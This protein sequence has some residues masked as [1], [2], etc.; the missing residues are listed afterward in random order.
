M[1]DQSLR[2]YYDQLLVTPIIRY[3]PCSPLTLTLI[4]GV[5][6]LLFIPALLWTSPAIALILLFASGYLDTLDGA[7]AR[8]RQQ[9]TAVG[10]V[11][12]IMTDRVVEFS[13]LF[14]LYLLDPVQRG[15]ATVLMLGSVFL[16]ITSFL[17]VGIFT[18]N[19]SGKSFHYS[20]GLME[21][22]EA[23][24]FFAAMTLLPG[25]FNLIAALFA[26]LVLI[27]A[28]IRIYEFIIQQGSHS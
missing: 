23:L 25:Y 10:A 28:I 15:L 9:S 14:G 17:V 6:G 12:D 4:A 7:L 21:R 19:Q 3:L 16:C 5:L 11:L 8:H 2:H 18:Q 20:P 1:L 24:L 13:A 27:T 22:A 26:I